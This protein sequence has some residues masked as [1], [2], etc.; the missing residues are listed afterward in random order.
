MV[1]KVL[2]ILMLHVSLL[3][4]IYDQRVLA[5]ELECVMSFTVFL[6]CL[7]LQ[8]LIPLIQWEIRTFTHPVCGLLV[9]AS[10]AIFP[11]ILLPSTP[12][13]WIA[14]MTFGYG[15][16]FLLI[17]SAAAV[18]VSLPYFIGQLFCHKI[19]VCVIPQKLL[20]IKVTK[21]K[22]FRKL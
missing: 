12:S 4:F 21:F 7:V 19:Q 14:G 6:T 17:I 3:V 15:Y 9:F 13:M 1:S 22:F 5:L 8:E 20:S 10:V 16:G 18:G 2:M 11:T